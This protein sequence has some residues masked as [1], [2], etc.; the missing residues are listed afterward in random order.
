MELS[1]QKA[2]E[3][4]KSNPTSKFSQDLRKAIESGQLDV[5][6]QKQGVDLTPFGRQ[7]VKEKSPLTE[8]IADVTGGKE[9]AQGFGQALAQKG[10]QKLIEETQKEQF[11]LQ[12][13][14]VAQIKTAKEQGRDTTRLENALNLLNEDV[15]EFGSG[16]EKLL[17]PNELTNKEVVGDALQLATTAGGAKVAGA[18]AGK[19][20]GATTAGQGFIQ[21]AKAGLTGGAVTGAASGAAQGLQSNKDTEGILTDTAMGAGIG[22]LGGA[23]IG[24]I[25]GGVSV[26]MNAGNGGNA[27]TNSAIGGSGGGGGGASGSMNGKELRQEVLKQQ[28]AS[29]QKPPVD[30]VAQKARLREAKLQGFEDQDIDFVSSMNSIDKTKAQKM[31][32]IADKASKNKRVLERPIDVV[33]DSMVDRIKFIENANKDAGKNLNEVAKSLRGQAVDANNIEKTAQS[34]IDDL[35]ITRTPT[36]KLNFDNSVFKNTPAIQKKLNK[37]INEIPTGQAD[38]YDVHIFK[39]SIDELVEFGTQG[40][41]LKGNA[42][43]ILKALR[44]SADEALDTTFDTYNQANTDFANTKNILNQAEE[45]FGKKVGIK[46]KERGGQLL[47]SV[48]SNNTQRPRVLKLVEEL[49]LIAKNYGGKF[50]DNLLDQALF[51]EILEDVYGTQATT[52]LQGQVQRAVTGGKKIVEAIKNP[53]QGAGELVAGATE[54]ILGISPENK[55]K[56]LME[57]LK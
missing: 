40:E 2:I 48:F 6:A 10:T 44:A 1:L 36:G 19:A 51:T 39:K 49:D 3:Q 26:S 5:A 11:D 17:N 53:V 4:A 24:G 25:I 9:I 33:G 12:G 8:R 57:L 31:V 28:I 23:I 27:P 50:D 52:S 55:K 20:V 18:V 54:K 43:R 42:E 30:T 38:A 29:G 46:S 37:F 47:R 14:L 45:L 21:G 32:D 41:G 35:G 7:P 13:K 16:A 34:L 22:G 15:Q 56:I